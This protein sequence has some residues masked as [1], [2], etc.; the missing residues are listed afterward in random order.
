MEHAGG[1]NERL[2]LQTKLRGASV[3][4][5]TKLWSKPLLAPPGH[6]ESTSPSLKL[7][8]RLHCHLRHRHQLQNVV[9]F[10]T[11]TIT[12]QDDDNK[13]HL[14]GVLRSKTVPATEAIAPVGINLSE[15]GVKLE[16]W[17][18]E[19]CKGKGGGQCERAQRRKGAKNWRLKKGPTKE[20]EN[21]KEVG[22]TKKKA[23]VCSHP[24][25]MI[26]KPS[27]P[28]LMVVILRMI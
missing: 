7:S 23:P 18:E 2:T 19:R 28:T 17:G 22:G 14:V 15:T 3:F 10:I 27:G 9:I 11:I 13:N 6:L 25:H 20:K 26:L 12:V 21:K 4:A 8:Y 5:I 16:V 24:H 1:N